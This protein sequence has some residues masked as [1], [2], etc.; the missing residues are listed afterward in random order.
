MMREIVPCGQY[1]PRRRR[2]L[3]ISEQEEIVDEYVSKYFSQ[4]EIA[5]RFRITVQLVR[6]LV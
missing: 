1:R 5:Q 4:K 6:D 3:S 2:L